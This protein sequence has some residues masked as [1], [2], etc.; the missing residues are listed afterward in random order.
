MAAVD[1]DVRGV[2]VRGEEPKEL[3]LSD[4]SR[5]VCEADPL[6]GAPAGWRRTDG[7]DETAATVSG[8]EARALAGEEFAGY[9]RVRT[10][11]ES[12]WLRAVSD[13]CLGEARRLDGELAAP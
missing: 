10:R 12:E 5:L 6:V 9:V 1:A 2:W 11:A 4:G 13:W 8:A 3:V 7:R